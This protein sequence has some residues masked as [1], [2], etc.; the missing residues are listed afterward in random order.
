MN[1]E[2][3][4][5]GDH[6]HM[7]GLPCN[8]QLTSVESLIGQTIR[9]VY[10]NHKTVDNQLVLVTES[11]CWIALEGSGDEDDV[12]V[13][14]SDRTNRLDQLVYERHLIESGLISTSE[15]RQI[16]L[17][18]DRER[19][20]EMRRGAQGTLAKSLMYARNAAALEKEADAL[21]AR[22]N[23]EWTAP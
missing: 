23:S 14:A 3:D 7:S 1:Q 12:S 18:K 4:L 6:V 5:L 9:M 20:A 21:E 2:K 17:V 16:Q 15:M 19:L 10:A 13:D 22:L 11:G 8:V